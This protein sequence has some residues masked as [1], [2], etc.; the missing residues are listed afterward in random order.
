MLLCSSVLE[1]T[2]K[3]ICYNSHC[4][5][6]SKCQQPKTIIRKSGYRYKMQSPFY[7]ERVNVDCV[8]G[9]R[10]VHGSRIN[11]ACYDESQHNKNNG[12]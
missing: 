6:R 7:V 10:A 2:V 5:A 12:E 9:N 3:S 11:V 4:N 8:W 1:L